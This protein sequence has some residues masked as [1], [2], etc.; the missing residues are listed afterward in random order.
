MKAC[1]HL[2]KIKDFF[3]GNNFYK[4]GGAVKYFLFGSKK[5]NIFYKKGGAVKYFL[6]GS[7]KSNIFYK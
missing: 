6:F 3:D 7:K 2:K 4:K 1:C 5:S